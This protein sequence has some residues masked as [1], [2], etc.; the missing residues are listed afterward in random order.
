VVGVRGK[1]GILNSLLFFA[2]LSKVALPWSNFI[3][4]PFCSSLNFEITS[5]C[6]SNLAVYSA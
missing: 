4:A 1:K 2:Y 3:T 5:L 6:F